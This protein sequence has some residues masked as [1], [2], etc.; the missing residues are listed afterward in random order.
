MSRRQT[1]IVRLRLPSLLARVDR[2]RGCRTS[3]AYVIWDTARPGKPTLL[4]VHRVGA[5]TLV[6]AA[7]VARHTRCC[8][9]P[10]GGGE[11]VVMA[12][13][14]LG[15]HRPRVPSA[16]RGREGA[17]PRSLPGARP[18]IRVRHAGTAV[19]GCAGQPA[20]PARSNIR[21]ATDVAGLRPSRPGRRGRGCHFRSRSARP[22]W[23]RLRTS[24]LPTPRRSD[25]C[26]GVDAPN[27]STPPG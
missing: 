7:V 16:C 5:A 2:A 25:G 14:E 17:E 19:F 15:A 3:P 1:G 6:L 21:A 27:A 18:S 11:S 22:P 8:P 10:E 23:P 20:R 13:S 9:P 12:V 26:R 24:P 4:A